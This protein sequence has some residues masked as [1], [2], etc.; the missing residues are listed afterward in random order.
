MADNELYWLA[1]LLEGEGCFSNRSDRYCSPLIQLVMTDRDVVVRAARAMGA[2]KVIECKV[3]RK[4]DKKIYR[5]NVYG[6]TALQLM[7]DLLPHMGERRS[8][9]ILEILAADTDRPRSPYPERKS[10]SRGASVVW[11]AVQ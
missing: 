1:G 8:A 3:P 5:T 2:H 9:K 4:A 6:S 7:R 10:Y 11:S